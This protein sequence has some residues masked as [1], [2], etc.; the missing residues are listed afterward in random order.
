M[1]FAAIGPIAA[2]A[3]KVEDNEFLKAQSPGG[4]A[5]IYAKTGIRQRHIA[6]PDECASDLGVA[7]AE[8]CFAE[9][10]I[11]RST[12]DFLLSAPKRPTTSATT[13]A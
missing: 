3:R 6:G 7:A 1:K 12:I 8:R 5:L 10:N 9:N 13:P 11:D 2:F 4:H